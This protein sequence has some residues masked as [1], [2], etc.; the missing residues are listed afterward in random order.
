MRPLSTM[1]PAPNTGAAWKTTPVAVSSPV[2]ADV[3]IGCST[4][5]EPDAVM[6]TVPPRPGLPVAMPLVDSTVPMI[7]PLAFVRLREPEISA[8]RMSISFVGSVRGNE[9]VPSNFSPVATIGADWATGPPELSVR[10]CVAVFTAP[11]IAIP[12]DPTTNER[13][14]LEKMAP[15]IVTGLE[16]ARIVVGLTRPTALTVTAAVLSP[17]PKV[18]LLNPG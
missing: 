6:V 10:L 4:V 16:P 18:M 15:A 3:S 17:R 1:S 13:S 14:A 8:A 5:I 9:A 2:P 7:K 12:P 11:L